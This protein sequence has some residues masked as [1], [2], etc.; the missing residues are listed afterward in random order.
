[1]YVCVCVC[2]YVCVR[3]V[4]ILCVI[5]CLCSSFC[6]LCGF[7]IPLL[8][9]IVVCVC[10]GAISANHVL[11]FIR[12]HARAFL[13]FSNIG[14]L[15]TFFRVA[16]YTVLYRKFSQ[17]FF[18]QTLFFFFKA[19]NKQQPKEKLLKI[20]SCA[21]CAHFYVSKQALIDFAKNLNVV[22]NHV[23]EGLWMC[24]CG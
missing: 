21:S 1:M 7:M 22:E 19:K 5:L 6:I 3:V 4:V 24:L 13:F 8:F 12:A 2:V 9:A 16:E 18:T 15:H 14:I 11:C 17:Y 20:K 10:I 23:A